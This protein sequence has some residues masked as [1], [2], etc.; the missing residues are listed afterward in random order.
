DIVG[1]IILPADPLSINTLSRFTGIGTDQI[2]N[3]LDSFR[4]VLSIPGDRDQPVRILHLSFRDFLVRSSSKFLV[5]ERRKHKEIA[6]CCL[7]T[8]QSHLRKDICNLANPRAQKADNPQDTRQYL[9]PE[10]QYS[11]RYWIHHLK[12]SQDLS[13][14]IEDVLL[15][16]Q[17]HFLHWLEAMSL[18]GLISEVV[19]MLDLLHTV[20]LRDDN[21]VISD[22]LHDGTRFVLKNRQ[23]ANE[24]PL[25][26][27]YAGL[28]FTTRTTIIRREF[29]SELPG[30][31]CQ[32]P[33]VNEKWSAELQTLEGHS[34]WVHSVA[35]SPDGRLLASTAT[36]GL[37]ETLTTK[38]IVN[39]L[40]FSQDGSYL[41]TNLGTL[42]VQSGHKYLASNS[43]HKNRA[44]FI[45]QG[46]WI[47]MNGKN[48]LWLSPDFRPTCSAINGD[49]LAL[50]HESGRVSF[51]RFRL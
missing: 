44:I 16:L 3:R 39:K 13:S 48:V 50:G 24:A 28:V 43:T 17:K 37:Q 32:F 6:H 20:K 25:Q 1:I 47:N 11:C 27:Y 19:G 21:P 42:D 33:Q 10:L 29:K 23:I 7:K 35:F 34:S 41:I 31:I 22:F 18:L 40:D 8:M 38:G 45:E 51:L 46:R 4:S 15:F 14:G 30:W 9:P 2:S 12:Q 26:I 36:G 5:D 49:S